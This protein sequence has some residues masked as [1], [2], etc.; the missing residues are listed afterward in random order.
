MEKIYATN[1]GR[2]DQSDQLHCF[3]LHFQGTE[4]K[5]PPCS[6]IAL[7]AKLNALNL[8]QLLLTDDQ[9]SDIEVIS[10]CNRERFL[11]LSLEQL[12]E[13]KDLIA[14]TFFMLELNNLVHSVTI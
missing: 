4:I 5:L 11:I 9:T 3:F 12:I 7:K 13:L 1:N 14:G 10:V 8:E 2:I 6:L